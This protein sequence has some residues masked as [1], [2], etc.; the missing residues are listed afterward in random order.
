LAADPPVSVREH[1]DAYWANL[2]RNRVSLV[3][4]QPVFGYGSGAIVRAGIHE[5][6]Y[7]GEFNADG[8]DVDVR[9]WSPNRIVLAATPN[10]RMRVNVNP[11]N[12]W[13]LNGKRPFR[14]YRP[15]EPAISF[16]VSV[17]RSG[18]VDMRIRPYLLTFGSDMMVRFTVPLLVLLVLQAASLAGAAV[19]AYRARRPPH[20]ECE[21]RE[22]D[23]APR[24]AEPTR[25]EGNGAAGCTRLDE[26]A[27][28][29]P[30]R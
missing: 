5:E 9:M 22:G 6:R 7:K 15:A 13:V 4:V 17:P 28:L 26:D 3:A 19:L 2:R 12:Y 8:S 29:Q 18:V 25:H 23:D 1:R 20:A 24:P 11:G 10:D 14:A 27:H 21:G 16:V 30:P